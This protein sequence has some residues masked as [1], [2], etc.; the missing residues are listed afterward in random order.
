MTIA[1][2]AKPVETS[3]LSYDGSGNTVNRTSQPSILVG[4]SRNAQTMSYNAEG[5][6]DKIVQGTT[7]VSYVDTAEREPLIRRDA[8]ATTLYLFDGVELT[9]NRATN[10]QSMVRHYIFN[11][12]TV[13]VRTGQGAAN[14]FTLWSDLNNTVGWQ[15]RNSDEQLATRRSYPYG[16]VRGAPTTLGTNRGFVDGTVDS[17]VGIVR[18]GARDYDPGSGRFLSPDPV[19]DPADPGQ[20]NAYGYGNGNPVSKPDPTGL[21]PDQMSGGEYNAFVLGHVRGG[22]AGA[23]KSYRSYRSRVAKA[24]SERAYANH[25]RGER[26]SLTE[27]WS[28]QIPSGRRAVRRGTW[29]HPH[30]DR[31]EVA[32][33][34]N[35]GVTPVAWANTYNPENRPYVSAG[36]GNAD[37][38]YACSEL[39]RE[40]ALTALTLLIPGGGAARAGTW[41][42]RSGA[43]G[44]RATRVAT[45]TT[46]AANA[47]D[48]VASASNKIYSSRAL[49]RMADE[50]GPFHNFPGSFDETIFSQGNRTVVPNYFNKVKPNLGNDS[51]QYGLPGYLNGRAGTYEIFTRPSVSS[52]TE[53]IM[54][55][56][57]R[58]DY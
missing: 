2:P 3:N 9:L 28:R 50:P 23:V 15:I 21:R 25:R 34:R 5:R 16:E 30:P 8:T 31:Y 54:H 17:K 29:A 4:A 44:V 55:R 38:P 24:R 18:I 49:Q 37:D 47:A 26:Q 42:A 13:A 52:R 32:K 27:G 19:I 12:E 40:I 46:R 41:A 1:A 20:W 39:Q 45:S 33:S 11:G 10:T 53:L 36:C 6:L 14:V 35:G 57:F 51:I 56:F 48:D 7:T 43:W 58:S 22:R